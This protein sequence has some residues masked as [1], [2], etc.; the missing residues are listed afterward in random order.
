MNKHELM[1]FMQKYCS[2]QHELYVTTECIAR[3]KEKIAK[4][5]QLPK[6]EKLPG[7][8]MIIF[9]TIIVG[10]VL[11][12]IVGALWGI[13]CIVE[14]FTTDFNNVDYNSI[15]SVVFLHTI[16]GFV[17]QRN[18]EVF[19]ESHPYLSYVV[20]FASIGVP[21]AFLFSIWSVISGRKDAR[22][23][24]F[25]AL[26]AYNEAQG[27]EAKRVDEVKSNEEKA[28][29]LRMQMKQMEI[30]GVIPSKYLKVVSSLLEYLQDGRADTLKEAINLYESEYAAL[31]RD[32]N[33]SRH[34]KH[35]EDLAKAHA[36]AMQS[37]AVKT[38]KAAERAASAAEE[39]AFWNQ[40]ETFIVANEIDK[41]KKK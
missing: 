25:V 6:K 38:R 19:V 18:A 39:A 33:E 16:I 14:A 2:L 12:I 10:I 28:S 36:T 26:K 27:L 34:R 21:L 5:R 15:N 17:T 37:E 40:A 7:I 29:Q 13:W 3:L 1:A 41:A 22:L 20:G 35:M 11:S 23:S 8:F 24:N 32:I 30:Q 9:M 4:G 31:E